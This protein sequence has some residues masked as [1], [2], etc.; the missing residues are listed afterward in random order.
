MEKSGGLIPMSETPD[1]LS[2]GVREAVLP[3]YD[4]LSVSV[5]G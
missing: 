4:K 3:I 2:I 1:N 5:E